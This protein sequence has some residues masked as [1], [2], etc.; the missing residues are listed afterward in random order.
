MTGQNQSVGSRLGAIALVLLTVAAIIFGVI[1]FQQRLSFDVP[2]DGISWLDTERGVQAFYVAPSSP[3]ERAGIKPGDVLL[4]IDGQPV[5]RAVQVVKRLWDL[6]IWSQAR[7]QMTRQ[8]RSFDTRLI[9][10]A[11]PKPLSIEN[12]LRVVG[13][14]YLFIGIFI[15]ARRWNAARAVH[16]YTFCLASFVLCSFHYTGKMNTFDWEVYWAKLGALLIAPALLVHFA[17]VFPERSIVRRFS[18]RALVLACY[19][20]PLALLIVHTFVATD[21][22]GFVPTLPARVALDQLELGYLGA[23]F[24]LAAAIFLRSYWRAP[25]GVLRQQLKWVT[26]GTLSGILPFAGFYILPFSLGAV[27][28]QWMNLS[29]LSL[30]LIP[31][32]FAYAIVRYRLMDVDI[33]FR[34]GLV[35]TAATGAVVAAYVALVA[36]IG[37]LFHT[38]WPS[39]LLGEIIAIVVAA[40]LFQPFRDWTQARLDRLFYRD[41]LNYRRTLIEFGRTLTSEVHVEPMLASVMDRL[42]QT[43]LV[44]RLAVFL[45]CSPGSGRYRLARSHGLRISDSVSESLNLSFLSPERPELARG[46]LFYDSSRIARE[47][48]ESVR[49]ALEHLDL[50]Y[51][52]PCRIHDRT[53]AILGLGKTVHGDFL[54]S[55]DVELVSTIAGYLAI[56]LDNAHLYSSLEQKAQQI[57][58]LKDFSENIV[59]SLNVGV[60]AVDFEGRIEFWN[61]QIERSIGVRRADAVGRAIGE[62]L[63]ADLAAEITARANEERVTSFYK[64]PLR[65]RSGRTLVANI[66]IA[67]LAGKSGERRG[68]LILVDD[69]TQRMQL[70]EQLLQTEK[71]TSLG[72]LAAGVAHE[73]NTPLAVISNY[74]QMLAKQLPANDP[75]HKLTDKI[76]KQTFR[77][78]EIVNNLLNFSRTGGAEFEEV[79]LNRVIGET[80]S[81]VAHPFR[82]SHVQVIENLAGDLPGVLGSGNR[83][84]QVFLNLFLNAKDAMPAGGMLEVRSSSVNGSVEIEISDTGIGIQREN[85]TRVFDPFFTTKATGRGTGLGLSVSYGIIKEHAGKIEVRST[86]GKGTS[87]RLEFPA[88]RKAVHA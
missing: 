3:G 84:Q 57:E 41:R 19:L 33:I 72:L 26:G 59:E 73:V 9:V 23:Y 71:L 13:S 68:R 25:S 38:A 1:N 88:V 34:R 63:P 17:L 36:V 49:D 16:F 70:E 69:I 64:F 51:F 83:L 40:F 8:S 6:G 74:I 22:A 79:N 42:S 24:L 48:S 62:I 39:G 18:S 60:L 37:A 30:A 11:A 61:T 2:E 86:P 46:Y 52:V 5:Y 45:D 4:S 56:A 75:R 43:L 77:A 32:C 21:L 47:R 85:L 58:R 10:A 55:E 82:A 29:A 81:L 28:R 67:P 7:Y 66:S 14:L 35:Y 53:V 78:S 44:D 20:P 15:F 12:Y 54:T 76:V 80:L 65:D 87:F 31:L 50:N 27:P